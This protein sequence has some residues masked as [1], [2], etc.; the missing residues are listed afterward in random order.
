MDMDLELQIASQSKQI[1]LI[2]CVALVVLIIL[3][4]TMRDRFPKLK[5]WLFGALSATLILPTIYFVASTIYLNVRSESG[6]PV[7]WHAEV[8]FW[9]CGAELELRN[10]TG[11]LSNKIGTSTYHEHDDKHIHLEGVVLRKSEDASL[12]KFMRVTGG[13]LNETGMGVPLNSSEADWFATGEKLD[14]DKQ[15]PENFSLATDATRRISHAQDGPVINLKNGGACSSDTEEQAFL[16][17]FVYTFNKTDGTYS[18][19]RLSSEEAAEY[20]IRDESSLGPPADCI[21]FE[22]DILKETTDKLCEQYGVRDKKRCLDFGVKPE[23][24]AVCD[25]EEVAWGTN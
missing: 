2:A 7:H 21:I 10:P 8:E 13:Y 24:T 15:Y 20:T 11:F 1:V 14:G 9:A 19:R 22:Y 5:P 16:Q 6:G 23:N 4:V 17:T 12:G 18:Q 3:S 25:I